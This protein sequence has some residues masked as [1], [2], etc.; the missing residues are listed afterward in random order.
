[1][2]ISFLKVGSIVI[3][4]LAIVF[5]IFAGI[6]TDILSA[7]QGSQGEFGKYDG[8]SIGVRNSDFTSAVSRLQAD[9][10]NNGASEQQIYF[11]AY[12]YT[13]SQINATQ[14]SKKAGFV[15]GK[16]LIND[17]INELTKDEMIFSTEAYEMYLPK[18]SNAAREGVRNEELNRL[19]SETADLLLAYRYV[20]D[21]FGISNQF[22]INSLM[23]KLSGERT[24]AGYSYGDVV[25]QAI[26]QNAN[27]N[28]Y[29][30][31]YGT[32]TSPVEEKFLASFGA[33]KKSF[34]LASFEVSKYP[35]E[36]VKKFVTEN[37]DLFAK[38]DLSVITYESKSDAKAA[39]K[40][41]KAGE[42][43][44]EDAFLDSGIRYYSAGNAKSALS[45]KYQLSEIMSES[46]LEKV[47]SLKKGEYS[48]VV[49]TGEEYSFFFCDE[50]TTAADVNS[51]ELITIAKNYITTSKTDIVKDYFKA[52]AEQLAE[53]AKSSDFAAACKEFGADKVSV[54]AF[55][56][57]YNNS[58]AAD[59]IPSSVY[60]LAGAAKDEEILKTLFSLK[61]V[62]DMSVPFENGHNVL[63]AKLT[64]IQND[65]SDELKTKAENAVSYYD[66]YSAYMN[67]T[68]GKNVTSRFD[69][70]YAE[71]HQ[72]SDRY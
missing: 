24:S 11:Q 44:I 56:V 59:T 49:K 22:Q 8:I 61:A 71:T 63:V 38:M 62:G 13:L 6:F 27:K 43:T 55:P 31:T 12:N 64:G 37:T 29:E 17:A 41:V 10:Q 57:N 5:F 15:P 28:G 9:S 16:Q 30:L 70:A 32:K 7:F 40:A 20:R 58:L 1:M 53:K 3:F 25:Q 52:K 47:C 67:I 72:N 26:F 4:F 14:K 54:P 2:K 50:D 60:Q 48:D 35:T 46:D 51:E 68:A 69:E 19:Y 45:Y 18:S 21:V 23:V 36:E 33:E 65:S 66:F 39:L 42:K 34:E